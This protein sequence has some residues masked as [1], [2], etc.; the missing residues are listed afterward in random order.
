M[1]NTKKNAGVTSS[2]IKFCD[3]RCEHAAFPDQAALDGSN[4]CRT[5]AALWCKE[6]QQLVTRN[7]P[8]AVLFGQ[9]RPKSNL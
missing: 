6:L 5:F 1:D 2:R 9:R 4:S 3:M 7:A 8:C